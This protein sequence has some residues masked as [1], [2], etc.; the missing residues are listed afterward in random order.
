MNNAGNADGSLPWFVK[1]MMGI[2]F[3]AVLFVIVV[4]LAMFL[5]VP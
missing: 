4:D 3:L 5:S 1:V 2:A